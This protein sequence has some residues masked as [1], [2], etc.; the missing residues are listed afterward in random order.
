MAKTG[1]TEAP[2]SKV[3][4]EAA[5]DQARRAKVDAANKKRIKEEADKAAALAKT[6]LNEEEKAFIARIEPKMK[7][8]RAVMQPSAAE[9][10]RYSQ[11][12]KRK[13]VKGGA[14]EKN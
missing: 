2:K 7:E 6:P 5:A 11:L 1:K 8:G 14:T 4:I 10:T 9:I 12:I 13:D 3:E